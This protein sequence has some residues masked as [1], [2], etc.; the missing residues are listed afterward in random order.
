MGT[1]FRLALLA[2]LLAGCSRR[3]TPASVQPAPPADTL[4]ISLPVIRVTPTDSAGAV[5]ID[6][7]TLARLER[8]VMAR[9]S[10]ILRAQAAE[11]AGRSS[12]GVPPARAGAPEIRHG[13]LGRIIFNDDGS[14]PADSRDRIAAVARLL[15]E[16]DGPVV[17]RAE[18]AAEASKLDV[19]IARARRVY[20]DLVACNPR[21]AERDVTFS[22]VGVN[23]LHPIEPQVEIFLRQPE[24]KVGGLF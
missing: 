17:I 22:I 16:M 2:L 5:A 24:S 7:A 15:D 6:S 10:A 19:A 9:I 20:R 11:R 3:T 23:S 13:L 1:F 12:A 8:T 21:L 14:M 4:R 18:A